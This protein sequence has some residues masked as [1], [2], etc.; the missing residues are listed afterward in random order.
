[1]QEKTGRR[2]D[3]VSLDDYEIL[4]TSEGL[5]CGIRAMMGSLDNAK[6]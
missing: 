1:M 6:R 5:L 2:L 4:G 3:N